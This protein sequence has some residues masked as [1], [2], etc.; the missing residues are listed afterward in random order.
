MSFKKAFIFSLLFHFA[1]IIFITFG[2]SPQPEL[3]VN[4]MVIDQPQPVEEQNHQ[5]SKTIEAV[6]INAEEIEA[7]VIKLKQEKA[8]AEQL[9][10]EKITAEKRAEQLAKRRRIAEEKRLAALKRETEKHAKKQREEKQR[11]A[12]LKKERERLQ[13]RQREVENKRRL[14]A[15]RKAKAE[16]EAERRR[17]EA[18]K[19][20]KAAAAKRV[21]ANEAVQKYK[22]LILQAIS[23]EWI[24]PA[25]INS[26]LSCEF[27]I[28]LAPDGTVILAQLSRSS[29]DMILDRSAETAINKA[30]PLP[31]PE[32]KELFELFRDI[33]LTVRPEQARG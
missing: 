17:V 2:S 4:A 21:R 16:K 22:V 18:I 28:R 13:K 10:K 6:S 1:I 7:A 3:I 32:D 11:L 14:E 31:V 9:R 25:N 24:L 23:K 26:Q 33:Q 27:R 8:Q 5:E 20:A 29:G 15:K 30:S 19:A 12:A